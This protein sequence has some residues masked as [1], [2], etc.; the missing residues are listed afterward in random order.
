MKNFHEKQGF[1]ERQ[2]VGLKIALRGPDIPFLIHYPPLWYVL[3]MPKEL[4]VYNDANNACFRKNEHKVCISISPSSSSTCRFTLPLHQLLLLTA[5]VVYILFPLPPPI[6]MVMMEMMEMMNI[7]FLIMI[8]FIMKMMEMSALP[9]VPKK[10]KNQ[11]TSRTPAAGF[12]YPIMTRLKSFL[13]LWP[14]TLQ[15]CSTHSLCTGSSPDTAFWT[16]RFAFLCFTDCICFRLLFWDLNENSMTIDEIYRLICNRYY[17]P[18]W[19][20][21]LTKPFPEVQLS[22]E[23]ARN[24]HMSTLAVF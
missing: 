8:V 22:T 20:L 4:T 14:R 15:C 10:S 13:V 11:R 12:S 18:K 24:Q 21:M 6:V 9:I 7:M 19:E 16:F 3:P 1:Y 2:A 5:T 23:I 17:K